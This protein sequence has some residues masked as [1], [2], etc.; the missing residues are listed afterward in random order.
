MSWCLT[1]RCSAGHRSRGGLYGRWATSYGA[2]HRA[3]SDKTAAASRR[4]FNA[5]SPCGP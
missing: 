2:F 1:S 5:R 4:R 3:G